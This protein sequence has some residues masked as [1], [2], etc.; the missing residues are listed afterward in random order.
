MAS[1]ELFVDAQNVKHPCY[2]RERIR[3]SDAVRR[4]ANQVILKPI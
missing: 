1:L 2:E 4:F 3:F